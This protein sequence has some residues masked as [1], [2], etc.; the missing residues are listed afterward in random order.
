M[1]SCESRPI[2]MKEAFEEML[3]GG[4]WGEMCKRAWPL[5]RCD[6]RACH[7]MA[8]DAMVELAGRGGS[9]I[10]ARGL[11]PRAPMCRVCC[12]DF[13]ASGGVLGLAC[14]LMPDLVCHT[15]C[16]ERLHRCLSDRDPWRLLT[17]RQWPWEVALC[18]GR[19]ATTYLPSRVLGQIVVL[20]GVL[21]AVH[22]G[23]RSTTMRSRLPRRVEVANVVVAA[24]VWPFGASLGL[25]GRVRRGSHF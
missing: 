15:S 17:R 6:R 22:A 4:R 25:S 3:V 5:R 1:T 16:H 9:R 8:R 18:S 23:Q 12:C 11:A 20:V 10:V 2:A 7:A 24:N 19:S 14:C 21:P 13:E